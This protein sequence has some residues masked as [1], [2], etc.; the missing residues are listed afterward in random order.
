MPLQSENIVHEEIKKKLIETGWKDG[1]AEL[2]IHEH[3]MIEYYLHDVLENQLL[4]INEA[5]FSNIKED[6]KREVISKIYDGLNSSE[7]KILEY[8]KYGI[9]I[10]VDGEI[11]IFN[12]IDYK[13]PYRN[14]FFFLYEAK[15][16]GSPDNSKPD[17]TLFVNGIPIVII[18]A[19]SES[20]PFSH[21]TALNDIRSYEMRSP[22]LFRFV[23]FAIA[24]GDE[25]RY[26]PTIPNWE[27]GRTQNLLL[28]WKDNIYDLL[29]TNTILE[30]IR[31]F[32]FFWSPEEGVKKKL[33]A[34][35]NQYSA[36]MKAMKRID[37]HMKDGKNRGLIW[38]WQGSGKTF[39]MFFIANYF[40][41]KY[42]SQN[43]NVFIV[44]DRQDLERQHDEVLKSVHEG[45]FRN[46]YKKIERI[47]ELGKIIETLKESEFSTNIIPHGVYLTTIQKFQKGQTETEELSEEEDKEATI[48]IY[49]LLLNL[50]EK[51]LQHL[52]NTN[53]E[54]H[55][56]VNEELALLDEKEREKYLLELGGVKSKSVLFLIDEAHRS[57]YS[58]LG[59][60]RKASFPNSASFGF[61]G[62]PIFKNEKNTFLEF[63]YPDDKEYYLDVYFIEESIKDGF[64]LS[65]TYE[66][67]K[68]GD[69]K[70]EGIKIKLS[71]NEIADFIKEYME[72][73]GR[74]EKILEAEITKKEI[75]DNITKAKV[76]LLN[77][78][79]IDKL[80][81]YIVKRIKEDTENFKF[82]VMVVAVNRLGCVRYKRALD[83]YLV[84]EFGEKARNWSEIVM[85]YNYKE[86]NGEIL[87]YMTRLKERKG[88][89][90]Y[91]EINKEIQDEFKNKEDPRILIVT[92]MLLTGFDAPRLKV[93]YLDKPLY[94]HRL[95]QAIA[96]VNRTY[97]DKEYGLIVDSVG[98]MEH[99]TKTM[100][101]Y[102]LLADEDSKIKEDIQTNLMKSIEQKLSEFEIKFK[103]LKKDLKN[104]KVAGEDVGIDLD[105]VITA[106]ITSS[107]I[108][109]LQSK[110]KMLAMFYTENEEFSA[111]LVRLVN[112]MKGILRLYKALGA[113]IQK[114][115][116]VEDIQALA[117]IHYRLKII[118]TPKG[119]GLGKEFWDEFRSFIHNRTIVEEFEKI[120]TARIE[121]EKIEKLISEFTDKFGEDTIRNKVVNELADYFFYLR[122]TVKENLHDPV[123]REI[124]E[125]LERLKKEWISRVINTKV[126]LAQLKA[127]ED[128]MQQY[129][130]KIEG[131]AIEDR[132]KESMSF[133][134]K[135]KIDKEVD[136]SNTLPYLKNIISTTKR[137]LPVHMKDLRTNILMDLFLAGVEENEARKLTEE[138]AEYIN[139]EIDRLWH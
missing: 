39:T 23:Q 114:L 38:H 66:V 9:K 18:E 6:D 32:I 117:Y 78:A 107:S 74:I 102:N 35:H 132:L 120:G 61:T 122:N 105:Y 56:K 8:L 115:V 25:K 69:V 50:A 136:F 70:A 77:P 58:I 71:E 48:G 49:S 33:I 37:E 60:M 106:L 1:N 127:I 110:I 108:D 128:N 86:K 17:F 54:E 40:L 93:M 27:K 76:I 83:K 88:N 101:I 137:L 98:L 131:K 80:A 12:L 57:H 82:K 95:L 139:E 19:K 111:K 36:T 11:K 5:A 104:L 68:E 44:V 113:Y 67:V 46:L 29:N 55:K 123:Y 31:Y 53:P 14:Y 15:F 103:E 22:E 130:S 121:P 3:E 99:L 87:N 24:Y 34:R 10:P 20:I 118:I 75:Q 79:R 91:N 112:E 81:E 90:G 96:R 97:P 16:K 52:K 21:Q 59:A 26:T 28:N 62:T 109:E 4:K 89:K 85:T 133:Y 135:Q 124:A 47:S 64:T 13:K 129:K 94:E 100:T 119:K 63:S 73:Q 134:I 30:Y 92:D 72:K 7:V 116:Y 65:I 41:D 45:K 51:H 43:P 126:F 138:L 125:K 84:Q 2:N 42:Y